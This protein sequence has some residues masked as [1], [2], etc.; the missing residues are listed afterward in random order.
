M[1]NIV[2]HI[3]PMPSRYD[4]YACCSTIDRMTRTIY[5]NSIYIHKVDSF[6]CPLHLGCVWAYVRTLALECIGSGALAASFGVMQYVLRRCMASKD[7]S[8]AVAGACG[9]THSFSG[10]APATTASIVEV[11]GFV[12]ACFGNR[13]NAAPYLLCLR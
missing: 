10:L 4:E 13:A 6:Y 1:L 12:R 11:S 3:L 8:L 5:D 9:A 7:N 2:M